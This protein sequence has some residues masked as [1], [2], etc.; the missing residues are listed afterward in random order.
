MTCLIRKSVETAL[1]P[2]EEAESNESASFLFLLGHG[3]LVQRR[4]EIILVIRTYR[5]Q[6]GHLI[7]TNVGLCNRFSVYV[8]PMFYFFGHL[9]SSYGKILPVM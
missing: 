9:T 4:E 8:L 1:V 6:N 2:V 3:R 5:C 7:G